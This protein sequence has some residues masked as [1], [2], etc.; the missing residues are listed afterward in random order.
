MNR[1]LFL[2]T[3]GAACARPLLAAARRPNVIVML[4]DDVGYGD[5]GCYGATRLR[6]PNL[7]RMAARGVRFTDA[8]SASAT[9]TPTRYALM[10]GEYAW[11]KPGTAILP[12]D[13][14][15]I[16][17]PSRSTLASVMKQA[18]YTTGCVGKWHLGLGK[19]PID[20]NG[21]IRP[22]PNEVGFDYSFIIPATGDRVPCVY[23]ENHRVVAL[24]PKDP[25]FVNYKDKIGNV[26]TGKENP[27]LLTMKYSHGHD[28]TI[29]NGISRIGWMSGGKA[30][31]WKD[32]VMAQTI[33]HQS[34]AFIERSKGKPFFLYFATHDI[35]V[36][37]VPNKQF[38]GTS[39]CGARCDAIQQL[40]WSVGQIMTTLEK[41]GL[42]DNTLVIFS[43]DNGPVVDDGYADGSVEALG[44]HLPAGKLRGGK[45]SI[46]EGGTRMPF[47]AQWPARIKPGV[48]GA[49]LCQVDLMASMAAFTGQRLSED[50]GPDSFNV[51]PALLNESTQARDHLVE[52]ARGIALRKGPWKLI[53]PQMGGGA[54]QKQ[55]KNTER[56]GSGRMELYNLAD[57][58]G[59]TKNLAEQN[60]D[61]A[62]EMSAM[63]EKIRAAGRSR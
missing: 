63:L 20:W 25:L 10:T 61:V 52:H 37:R 57:D 15:L 4:A 50:A 16:V 22:G 38:Q 31:W 54:A 21:E 23:V 12:G 17:D 2:Q 43:S 13:A 29:V 35:H 33:T 30:A 27:E 24:D 1:R 46:Y 48:S 32:E 39:Q 60:P 56:T 53:P 36:P 7:D 28:Q 5:L 9:C 47:V 19:G 49:L 34:T 3:A 55:K 44:P 62:R 41:N 14:N 26:P 45:Y 6:T 51:L 8:H 59:E 18:G 58:L 11:R 42:L 40:D